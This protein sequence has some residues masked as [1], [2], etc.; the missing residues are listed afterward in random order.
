MVRISLE[1][2]IIRILEK[3]D[4]R[5]MELLRFRM[6]NGRRFQAEML[7]HEPDSDRGYNRVPMSIAMIIAERR[8]QE[9][10]EFFLWS[11]DALFN[12][13]RQDGSHSRDNLVLVDRGDRINVDFRPVYE[14]AW[15][16]SRYVWNGD[17]EIEMSGLLRVPASPYP[18]LGMFPPCSQPA[19]LREQ[20]GEVDVVYFNRVD[21]VREDPYWPE[22]FDARLEDQRHGLEIEEPAAPAFGIS[23]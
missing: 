5:P 10:R 3:I 18:I 1:E 22:L 20:D 16:S 19:T 6:L 11:D 15:M 13:V 8:L 7:G 21:S 2:R 17:V 14:K 23:S 9:R 12:V 4:G